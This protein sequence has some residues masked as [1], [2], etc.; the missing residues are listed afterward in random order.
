M[1]DGTPAPD[2]SPADAFA[3]AGDAAPDRSASAPPSA[4][5]VPYPRTPSKKPWGLLV[6]GTLAVAAAG[7]GALQLID[8]EQADAAV[9]ATA[10]EQAR[11]VSDDSRVLAR[12]DDGTNKFQITQAQVAAEALNRHGAEVL[13]SM[14]NRATVKLA[15]DGRGVTVTAAEVAAEIT[16]A[17]KK[18]EVDR[19][20]YLRMLE[21]ERGVTP[22][23]YANDVVWPKLALKKLADT[24]VQVT[25]EDVKKA[26]IRTYGPKVKAR[27]IMCDNIRRAQQVHKQAAAN[28]AE[29]GRLAREHSIDEGSKALDGMIPPISMYGSP[30][31]AELERRAFA[32]KDGEVSGIVQLSFPGMN[33]YVILKREGLTEAAATR[34]EEVRPLIEEDLRERKVQESVAAVFTEIRD[35][36]VI[37]NYL[38]NEVVDPRVAGGKP[39]SDGL[40]R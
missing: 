9:A 22:Q 23:Q 8:T 33:R 7:A 3:P 31:T 13:E 17:A 38:T 14:I 24:Q 25:P 19:D 26:F 27:M 20:T 4:A 36:T 16:D 5:D 39:T 12:L 28:P 40:L 6:G 34:L 2:Y 18:Y 29:F 32:L 11:P 37:H 15:C 10:P 35:R 21:T 30:E 1:A